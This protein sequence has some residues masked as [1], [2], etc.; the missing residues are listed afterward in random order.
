[1]KIIKT[2]NYDEMSY[3]S[4]QLI[5]ERLGM[6]ESLVLGLATGGGGHL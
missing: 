3:Y 4:A 6:N 5:I 1:M 2:N